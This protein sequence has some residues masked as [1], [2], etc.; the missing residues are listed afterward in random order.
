MLLSSS[1]WDLL[2]FISIAV[3]GG[4]VEVV[5]GGWIFVKKLLRVGRVGVFILEVCW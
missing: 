1:N 4:I 3:D 5:G 2:D